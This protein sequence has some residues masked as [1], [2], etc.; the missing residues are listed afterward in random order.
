[1]S[2]H[3]HF[4]LLPYRTTLLIVFIGCKSIYCLSPHQMYSKL[5]CSTNIFKES[6]CFLL[7]PKHF[8]SFTISLHYFISVVSWCM[9]QNSRLCFPQK[10]TAAPMTLKFLFPILQ[11]KARHVS[12]A[13]N[14]KSPLP[15][16]LFSAQAELSGCYV[17][18]QLSLKIQPE[19]PN[20]RFRIRHLQL[21]VLNAGV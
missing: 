18:G 9:A 15:L 3:R 1:M 8:L 2:V 10:K 21:F 14:F 11:T 5:T 19:K 20:V 12:S 16:R 17:F 13:R 7:N 4:I 6:P